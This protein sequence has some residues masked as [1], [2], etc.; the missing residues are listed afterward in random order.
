VV[1]VTLKRADG[2]IYEV[3]SQVLVD[4]T[5]QQAFLANRLELRV[6]NPKLQ[7]VAIWGYYRGARRDP[8]EHGGATI[9]LHTCDK[10]SWFWYIPLAD[11][12]TSIGVV[13]DRDYLLKGRG[14]PSDVFEDELVKC[15]A[16]IERLMNAELTSELRTAKEFSYSTKQNAGDGWVMVG[17]AWG[18][19]DPIYSSGVYFALRSG[20]LAADAIVAGLRCGDTTAS[21]L[22]GWYEDFETGTQWIRKLVDAYYN[23][24]FSFGRFL[25]DYPQ[26]AG[27]LTDLLIGR[28]FHDGAGE[29]FNDMEPELAKAT[30][31]AEKRRMAA[32]DANAENL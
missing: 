23:N 30:V 28:I 26:H 18:F 22:S 7:K 24:D 31:A 25:R 21:Q 32:E 20:E 8:G 27:N 9:I 6:D 11:D 17:D 12:V 13:G 4:A 19:I 5:G 29:I 14:Q 10:A 3:R 16:L 1:G 2:K 15:P